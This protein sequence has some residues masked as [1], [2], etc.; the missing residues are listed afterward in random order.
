MLLCK[1]GAISLQ[2][3]FVADLY[4]RSK[5]EGG[6]ARPISHKFVQQIFSQTWSGG[7]RLDVPDEAGGLLMPGD[8]G[9][10]HVTLQY[11]MPLRLGQKFTIRESSMTVASG[12]VKEFLPKV[13][14]AFIN[15]AK[16]DLPYGKEVKKK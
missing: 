1:P 7:A 16:F 2:N 14:E 13:N 10:V 5:E 8:H 15:F 12:I 11:G 3:R 9:P 6:R 4:L